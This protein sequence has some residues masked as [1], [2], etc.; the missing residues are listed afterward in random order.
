[1]TIYGTRKVINMLLE[2]NDKNFWQEVNSTE[3][4][5]V[6][7]WAPWCAPCRMLTP[8][9]EKLGE[10]HRAGKVDIVA[11]PTLAQQYNVSSIP[12]LLV[13]KNG[14]VIDRMVGL[15]SENKLVEAMQNA[16]GGE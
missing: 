1:M 9:M 13:F 5:L 12:A 3:P 11:H 16:I 10:T 6:D 7:F 15:Q 14:K 8:I 4:I 2:L